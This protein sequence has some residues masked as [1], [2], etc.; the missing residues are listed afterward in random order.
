M[1]VAVLIHI[2]ETAEDESFKQDNMS[3]KER[4]YIQPIQQHLCG[5]SD[6][7]DTTIC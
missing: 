4:F 3:L 6:G 2:K 1:L 5:Y 7:V